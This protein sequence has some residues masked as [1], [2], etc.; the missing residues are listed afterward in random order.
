MSVKTIAGSTGVSPS[1]SFFPQAV[2]I[3]TVRIS[4]ST[5]D[6]NLM[7]FFILLFNL[8]VLIF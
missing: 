1:G 5:S 8:F 4:K 2:S 3:E 6:A 7:N